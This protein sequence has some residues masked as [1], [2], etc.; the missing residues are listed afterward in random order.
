MWVSV[1]T[2]GQWQRGVSE[3]PTYDDTVEA[4]VLS[5]WSPT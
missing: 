4:G 5:E 3:F 1:S 2:L